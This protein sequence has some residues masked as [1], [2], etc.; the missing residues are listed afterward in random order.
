MHL[1]PS[2]ARTLRRV[3][4]T[5]VAGILTLLIAAGPA[6]AGT[7]TEIVP[8]NVIGMMFLNP[9]TGEHIT[10]TSGTLQLLVTM[11]DT[12]SG[13]HLVVHGNAQGVTAVGE[14]TGVT[15]R[16]AGDFWFET[17]VAAG[18]F[19][20]VVQMVETHD[21]ISAGS[22]AN[23]LVHLVSHLTINANGAVTAAVSSASA[24]C[25]G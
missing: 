1:S 8:E 18:G 7:F 11:N 5:A 23:V 24:E 17:N 3:L 16:L 13:L 2:H 4:T 25:R 22:T 21:V 20:V 14:S 15:Y 19:P 9:C 6:A 12:T 10:I